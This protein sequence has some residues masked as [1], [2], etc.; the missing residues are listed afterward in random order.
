MERRVQCSAVL[1]ARA[2]WGQWKTQRSRNSTLIV[3][4]LLRL[5]EKTALFR[6]CGMYC[7]QLMDSQS[8]SF[9]PNLDHDF[10]D[11]VLKT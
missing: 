2:T 10:V 4:I 11:G 8:Y 3:E 1:T 9:Q 5:K 7:G 6:V